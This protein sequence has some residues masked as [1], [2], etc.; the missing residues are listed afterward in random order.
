MEFVDHLKLQ[1]SLLYIWCILNFRIS[2]LNFIPLEFL[3]ICVIVPLAARVF[4]LLN[5]KQILANKACN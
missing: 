2:I 3:K 4:C 1:Y 5:E